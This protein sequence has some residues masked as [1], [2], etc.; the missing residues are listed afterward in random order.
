[1][2]PDG[3]GPRRVATA[4]RVVSGGTQLCRFGTRR[5]NAIRVSGEVRRG[6][7]RPPSMVYPGAGVAAVGGR[8]RRSQAS[9]R[10]PKIP[11][12][13]KMMQRTRTRP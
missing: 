7:S 8:R 1:M 4:S 10:L 6:P 13:R 9:R 5:R 12:G 3:T 11:A 2:F